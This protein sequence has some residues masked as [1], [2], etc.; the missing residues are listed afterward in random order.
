MAGQAKVVVARKVEQAAAADTDR[1]AFDAF[2]PTHAPYQLRLLAARVIAGAFGGPATSV[3]LSI[4]A[5]VVPPE[6]RGR[7]LGAVMGAFSRP[8]KAFLRAMTLPTSS[9]MTSQP[10]ARAWSATQR[11]A[12]ASA[13]FVIAGTSFS[14]ES[15]H[16][17]IQS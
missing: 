9:C 7:A 17:V 10:M 3:S 15:R 12:A 8:G 5:D 14:C 6:H 1:G 4:V 11:A 13:D 2:E 16:E